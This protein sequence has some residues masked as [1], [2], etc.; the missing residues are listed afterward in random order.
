[1]VVPIVGR[2][3]C[4]NLAC[5]LVLERAKTE[6][7][8]A[9]VSVP[10]D[11]WDEAKILEYCPNGVVFNTMS[12]RYGIIFYVGQ[13]IESWDKMI[14]RKMFGFEGVSLTCSTC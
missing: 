5:P 2:Y 12:S 4:K 14:A 3:A 8:K 11:G 13:F 7:E 10:G 1:M 6:A 9:K